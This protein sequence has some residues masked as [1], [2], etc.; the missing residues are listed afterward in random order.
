MYCSKC[1]NESLESSNFCPECGSPLNVNVVEE[2]LNDFT[3]EHVLS[4][5]VG[6]N[7][8][9]YFRKW[10]IESG[11]IRKQFKSCIS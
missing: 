2:E 11:A 8:D 7:A 6:K 4:S 9:V 3:D 5:Y 10:A 1:G